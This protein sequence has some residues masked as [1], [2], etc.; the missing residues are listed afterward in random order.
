MSRDLAPNIGALFACTVL[1]AAVA[2][3]FVWLLQNLARPDDLEGRLS[4]VTQRFE[5][6]QQ[7]GQGRQV[8]KIY[9]AES[10]CADVAQS[11]VVG[12][13]IKDAALRLN[14]VVSEFQTDV[15]NQS[16]ND[17]LTSVRFNITGKGEYQSAIRVM[18]GFADM[19]PLMFVDSVDL[20]TQAS[21]VQLKLK[22][23]FYCWP[24]AQS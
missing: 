17:P 22:G 7:L 10:V 8:S 3:G 16:K 9:P 15:Q 19:F 4:R 11:E 23:H 6:V 20:E 13:Q 2:A 24:D 5:R 12:Q 21:V 1:G 14:L 18:A